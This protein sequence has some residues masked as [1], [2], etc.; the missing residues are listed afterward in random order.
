MAE[1]SSLNKTTSDKKEIHLEKNGLNCSFDDY[2]KR[3]QK[4]D[5][6]YILGFFFLDDKQTYC[7]F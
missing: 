6:V 2:K 1:F 3:R 4:A 7:T 5:K